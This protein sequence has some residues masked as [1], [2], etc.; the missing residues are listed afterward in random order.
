[1]LRR[2]LAAVLATGTLSLMG[3]TSVSAQQ[4]TGLVNINVSDN[5][6]QVPIGIAA[7]I[8]DVKVIVLASQIADTG[9]AECTAISEPTAEATVTPGTGGA[10]SQEGLINVNLKNNTIQ[11]PIAAAANICRVDV[12]ILASAILFDDATACEARAGPEG[13]ITPPA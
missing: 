3:A 9:S 4:Q 11:V 12:V 13:I 7:N 6:I 10:A 1:M 5:V 8:C 2:F